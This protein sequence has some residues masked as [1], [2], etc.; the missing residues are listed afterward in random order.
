MTFFGNCNFVVLQTVREVASQ[1][2]LTPYDLCLHVI[3]R[4]TC[5]NARTQVTAHEAPISYSIQPYPNTTLVLFHCCHRSLSVAVR[6]WLEHIWVLD[7][8][9]NVVETAKSDKELIA[10]NSL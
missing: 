6:W 10:T 1:K 9:G 3:R 4:R 2:A 8:K 5:E 7:S